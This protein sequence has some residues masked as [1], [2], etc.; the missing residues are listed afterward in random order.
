VRRRRHS[1]FGAP[2][3]VGTRRSLYQR[4]AEMSE[5][6]SESVLKR[7][8]ELDALDAILPFD[9]RGQLAALLTN[10][11]VATLKHLASEGEVISSRALLLG[12]LESGDR[13][14]SHRA[15]EICDA[16]SPLKFD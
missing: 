10:D 8:E 11:D 1:G 14:A 6:S 9:G 12:L 5:A 13:S 2:R 7:A 4:P 3:D 16:S 15:P